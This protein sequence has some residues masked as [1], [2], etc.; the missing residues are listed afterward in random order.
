[1]TI[2]NVGSVKSPLLKEI[3]KITFSMYNTYLNFLSLDIDSYFKSL[4][5]ICLLYTSCLKAHEFFCETMEKGD[6]LSFRSPLV[7]QSEVNQVKIVSN[8]ITDGWFSYFKDQDV[9]MLN[10]YDLSLIH[11]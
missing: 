7:D 1:M 4:D 8:E 6:C 2:P 10:M 11:I 3:A 5:G 9:V